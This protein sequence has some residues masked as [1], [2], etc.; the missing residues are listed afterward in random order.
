MD[1][2]L[3]AIL[4]ADVVG[5]SSHMERDEAGTFARLKA[6]REQLFDPEIARHHGHVFKTMG[7]GLLAEFGSV[8]DAV[9][10]AVSL[11]RGL[12]ERN[13]SLPEEDRFQMRIGINLG[14]VIVDGDD[15]YGEGVNIA[16][17]LEQL[18]DPG[19]ICVSGKVAKEV[20]KKLA[21]SFEPMGVQK[22]KNIAEPIAVYRVKI[23]ATPVKRA[24]PIRTKRLWRWAAMAAVVALLAATWFLMAKH[25]TA[26]ATATASVPSIAVLPFDNMS[27]D[28][29]LGYLGDGIAEDIITMLSRFP[30]L[31]VIARNS[32]F[33]YKGKPEDARQIGKDLGAR[34]LLEGSVRKDVGEMRIVAQLIDTNS[35][36]HVWADRFDESGADP[37]ALQDAV[38]AKIVST[39]AGDH[40]QIHLA[41]YQR[42]WGKDTA[43]LEEYDY[44]LRAGHYL[45]EDTKDAYD[46]AA[47]IIREGLEKFP[48]STLLK[49]LSGFAHYFRAFGYYST[50]PEADYHEAGKLVREV[51]G[52]TPLTPQIARLGHWLMA[53]VLLQE[54]DFAK[55]IA[56]AERAAALAPYDAALAGNLSMVVTMSGKPDK[57]IEWAERGIA[58]D[59]GARPWLYYR[60]GLAYS[61]KGENEKA[62]A[63]LKQSIQF[64]DMVL[65]IAISDLR[66][67]QMEEAQAEY[68]RALALDPTFTQ[69]KWRKGYF[70]SDPSV[71]EG[72]IADLAKLGLPE[73]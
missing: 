2:K 63:A 70:Y 65:L 54:R 42:S 20:E 68:K 13:A 6:G 43:N 71:V 22:V 21:F 67:G 24:T 53:Y 18:A 35:G 12:A 58:L 25:E 73:K 33:A 57:G 31:A 72:Q 17:R 7:D 1:R 46:S 23:D 45:N 55:A 29:S 36:Q 47:A 5:Y 10:C 32:S 14:E 66:L 38:T 62:I 41:D 11:Q 52:T 50:D 8:V 27:G 49:V 9:E 61:L 26:P 40:G 60:L 69:A 3:A 19:G 59:V 34:Y 30:D 4:A 48:N 56:E 37:L 44:A 51:L 64:V 15:R 28:A 39:I 16:S